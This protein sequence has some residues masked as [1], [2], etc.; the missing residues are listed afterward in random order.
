MLATSALLG[1]MLSPYDFGCYVVLLSLITLLSLAGQFGTRSYVV[2][3]LASLEAEEKSAQ[4][5]PLVCKISGI[6]A[7]LSI[8]F[9]FVTF[10]LAWPFLSEWLNITIGYR[11]RILVAASVPLIA[12]NLVLPEVFRGIQWTRVAN[13]V[14]APIYNLLLACVLATTWASFSTSINLQFVFVILSLSMVASIGIAVLLMLATPLW[15]WSPTEISFTTILRVSTPFMLTQLGTFFM[16]NSDVWLVAG[17]LGPEDAGVYGAASRLA[18]MVGIPAQIGISVVL[19]RIAQL[20]A[21]KNNGAIEKTAREA[22]FAFTIF[23]SVIAIPFVLF[24]SGSMMAVYGSSFSDGGL[25]LS[26]LAL[27]QL[28]TAIAGPAQS[29]MMMTGGA[30]SMMLV[31][32]GVAALNVTAGYFVGISYGAVG[33]ALCYCIGLVSYAGMSVLL[34]KQ[35]LGIWTL[36]KIPDFTF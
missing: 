13:A 6:V 20:A 26:V 21:S 17:K 29:V 28:T 35:K 24:G 14:G 16:L 10:I 1:R 22:A 25:L 18:L 11:S 33:V 36:P 31:T 9:S 4:M 3:A 34:V 5:L 23:G 12:I 7:V 19:G 27:G 8:V 15:Q 2:K 30:T 32:V